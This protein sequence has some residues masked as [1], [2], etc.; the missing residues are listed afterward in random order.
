VSY[1]SLQSIFNQDLTGV[2]F[3]IGL[4]LASVTSVLF[5]NILPFTP[6]TNGMSPGVVCNQLTIGEGGALSILPLSQTVFGFTLAYLAYFIGVNSLQS[7][8]VATFVIFPMLIIAD[9]IWKIRKSCSTG[10]K[11]LTALVIGGS[12]GTLWAM[13][14]E[15]TNMPQL[16]YLSGVN[17]NEV[18]S[19]PSK[20]LYKCRPVNKKKSAIQ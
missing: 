2:V 13:I 1:F 14:I 4:L 20:S 3:L 11:L 6:P 9:M 18:C 17:N 12:I 7:Q 5:G 19:K 15:A 8:N 16:A 10:I